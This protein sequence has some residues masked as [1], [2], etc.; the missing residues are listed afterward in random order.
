MLCVLID[1]THAGD[2]EFRRRRATLRYRPEYI[3]DFAVP[4]SSRFPV[5]G[6]E[7]SG[8][9]LRNWLLNL[10][11][12]DESV[13]NH[14]RSE[15]GVA[16]R[17]PLRLLETPMGADCAGAV[18]FCLPESLADLLS[19]K[20]GEHPITDEEIA[21]WLRDYPV[22]PT[23]M[24][25]TRGDLHVGFSLAGM[26]PKI[27]LRSVADGT[28]RRPW[29]S[30]PT[31]HIIKAARPEY[32][33]ECVF[34]HIAM[35]TAARLGIPAATTKVAEVDGLQVIVV[36]RFDRVGG[37][38]FRIHQEDT[39]QALGMP[40]ADKYERH[41][42]PGIADLRRLASSAGG[43]AAAQN[44]DRLRDMLIYH[45]LIVNNDA[46]AK[47]FSWLF[48]PDGSPELSPLYDACSWLPYRGN[49]QVQRIPLA[50]KMG[51]G[52]N[53][54]TCDKEAG[55][56]G[57][58]DK[59]QRPRSEICERAVELANGL[60]AALDSTV[61]TLP[62]IAANPQR[63]ERHVE[64]LCERAQMCERLAE[65]V[66]PLSRRTSSARDSHEALAARAVETH[67]TSGA[68]CGHVGKVSK[69][70]CIRL[71]HQDKNHR[72]T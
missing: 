20:G 72:Y 56:V 28:W 53:L 52:F 35:E 15:F 6:V 43:T 61:G 58:A 39:C 5:A 7:A 21:E 69:K 14:L 57:L 9:E 62:G 30:L 63:I 8:P 33:D 49:R 45:W 25:G 67:R 29:G 27:A 36:T 46:H 68:R 10:L 64:E 59:L 66:L 41:S 47:N 38:A 31:T 65:R 71:V 18:Q 70:Q 50:M 12:D 26:Q 16:G 42:G 44:V 11:P 22:L 17:D 34:E 48:A 1:G 13:L 54:K 51:E 32:P 2:I 19:S 55:L 60:P 4:L 23:S 3:R 40:P 24:E 37:G